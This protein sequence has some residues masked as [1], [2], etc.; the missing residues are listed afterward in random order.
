[1]VG[2]L[3]I[4]FSY[5]FKFIIIFDTRGSFLNFKRIIIIEILKKSIF[6]FKKII[7]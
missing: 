4:D 3:R 2:S 6:Y 1:M 7:L 5:L